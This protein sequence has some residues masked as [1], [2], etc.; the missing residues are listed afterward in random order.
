VGSSLSFST[1]AVVDL[2]EAIFFDFNLARSAALLQPV[3]K[4]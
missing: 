4:Y 1:S 3:A 2:S